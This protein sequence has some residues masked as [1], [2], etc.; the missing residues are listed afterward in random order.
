LNQRLSTVG[1]DYL[2]WWVTWCA[3]GFILVTSVGV[4]LWCVD[5]Q[6]FHRH[7]RWLLMAV[8]VG[9]LVV[10]AIKFGVARPRPLREFAALLEAGTIHINVIGPSLRYRSF[11]SGHTQVMASVSMYLFCLYLR[12]WYWWSASLFLVG[13][14]RIYVG[15]HFPTDVLA[16]ALLGMLSTLGVWHWRRA[17][18]AAAAGDTPVSLQPDPGADVRQQA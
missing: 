14:S 9:G 5:R 16:G 7:Y 6:T 10:Q 11:P 8:L 17:L 1:L 12:Q 2:L 15:V 18:S 4:I 13:L 3:D